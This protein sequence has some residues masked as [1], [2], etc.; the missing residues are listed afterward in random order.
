MNEKLEVFMKNIIWISL[1]GVFIS[2]ICII[3]P[4]QAVIKVGIAGDLTDLRF[5]LLNKSVSL[6]LKF[7]FEHFLLVF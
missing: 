3:E 4:A 7:L 2:V 6:L 1:I 5:I